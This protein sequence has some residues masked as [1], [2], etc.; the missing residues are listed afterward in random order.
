MALRE[1]LKTKN[2]GVRQRA[3]FVLGRFGAAAI[4]TIP[5]LTALF[6]DDP[7]RIV[8]QSAADALKMINSLAPANS[9]PWPY[10]VPLP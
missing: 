1:A 9:P 3:C 6:R 10:P 5:D 8:K 2:E 4:S 7:H